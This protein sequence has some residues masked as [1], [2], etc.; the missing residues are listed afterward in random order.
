MLAVISYQ[1]AEGSSP[2][3]VYGSYLKVGKITV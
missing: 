3:L 1:A 2:V